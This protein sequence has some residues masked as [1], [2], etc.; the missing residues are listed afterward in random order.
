MST[1]NSFQLFCPSKR[2]LPSYL[3]SVTVQFC[4]R[5]IISFYIVGITCFLCLPLIVRLSFSG[6]TDSNISKY[7]LIINYMGTLTNLA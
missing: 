1:T 3:V 6:C 2:D 7:S 5:Y 4:D